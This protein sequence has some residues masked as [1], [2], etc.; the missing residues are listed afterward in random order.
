MAIIYFALT[1][2]AGTIYSVADYSHISNLISELGAQ[3]TQN[4]FIMMSGF[5]VLGTGLVISG[6]R[7]LSPAVVPFALFG[8][9]MVMAGAF[10][11]KPV[12]PD[13]IY[14]ATQHNLHSA[15]A[16]LAGISVTVGFVWQGLLRSRKLPK[17]ICFYL[18]LVCI[19][20]PMLML[21]VP[22]Y[23]GIFQRL[24]YLQIFMWL[25]VYYPD[26]IMTGRSPDR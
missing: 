20:F 24:M 11:H 8:L 2:A 17:S 23:Q 16:T 15:A 6:A 19:L 1:V 12:D 4:N 21:N 5:F 9:F 10:R 25:W 26:R 3:K 22:S 7:R 18:A 14:S 13:Q